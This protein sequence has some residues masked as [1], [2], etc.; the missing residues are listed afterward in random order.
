MEKE[1]ILSE[2]GTRLGQ[3]SLSQ[4]TLSDYVDGNLP[5]EGTEP[6]DA[7]WEKHVGFLKSLGGNFS[8]DVATAVEDFKKGY[9]PEQKE[10]ER[11]KPGAPKEDSELMKRL[12]ALEAKIADE[13]KRKET[14][15]LRDKVRAKADSLKVANKAL[16][17]DAVGMVEISDGMD[18]DKLLE[19]A[20]KV[21]ESKLKAYVGEGAQPYGGSRGKN[22]RQADEEGAKARR[23]AFLARMRSQGKLPKEGGS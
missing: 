13:E 16:F 23:E 18:A 4:R 5:A 2:I 3:T 17:E 11:Q 1:Q 12:S 15:S 9:K 14:A 8:H 19:E 6:D 21:Y 22:T 20:K 10:D 7:Y